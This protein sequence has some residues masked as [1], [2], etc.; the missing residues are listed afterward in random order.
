M[1]AFTN[2]RTRI[3]KLFQEII[4]ND[5]RRA[6]LRDKAVAGLMTQADW[7]DLT[8]LVRDRKNL[9]AGAEIALRWDTNKGALA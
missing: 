7:R 4:E 6:S 9:R 2:A 8:E 3:P 5:N 1:A